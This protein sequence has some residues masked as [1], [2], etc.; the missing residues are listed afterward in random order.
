M[1][2]VPA[3]AIGNDQEGDYVLLA[4]AGDIVARRGV[5][6]GPLTATGCALRNGLTA[7]D[8]VIVNGMTRAKPG[9]KVTPM[10]APASQ[11]AP[12]GSSR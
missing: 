12:A 4:E 2:V 7:G 5:V 11:S 3:S 6:K 10:T 9:D 8:R 1:L